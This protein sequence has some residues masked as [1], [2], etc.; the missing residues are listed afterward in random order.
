ME[1][2]GDQHRGRDWNR[3]LPDGKSSDTMAEG[4][5][6]RLTRIARLSNGD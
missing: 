5:K 6:V 2:A 4:E 3:H 1:A